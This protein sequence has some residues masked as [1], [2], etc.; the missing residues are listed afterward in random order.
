MEVGGDNKSWSARTRRDALP[1]WGEGRNACRYPEGFFALFLHPPAGRSGSWPRGAGESGAQRCGGNAS[2]APVVPRRDRG[3][4]PCGALPEG[5]PALP[6]S[7]TVRSRRSLPAAAL[8]VP[9]APPMRG[10]SRPPGGVPTPRSPPLSPLSPRGNASLLPPH[11]GG[12]LPAWSR[13]QG[14]PRPN[15]ASRP[16]SQEP[17]PFPL[18]GVPPA[19]PRLA[20]FRLP[21]PASGCG[22]TVGDWEG[23]AKGGGVDVT[24]L[25]T[26]RF[27]GPGGACPGAFR[28]W[29]GALRLPRA[30][31][32]WRRSGRSSAA[33]Q[34]PRSRIPH[35]PERC[36][37]AGKGLTCTAG[38][39]C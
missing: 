26:L 33:A 6:P 7:R 28:R 16:Q 4:A 22:G 34:V 17:F 3:S 12:P 30:K 37:K 14:S 38:L 27:P 29:D 25:Q 36:S 35:D 15:L 23:Q 11:P 1:V 20:P 2:P 13:L 9:P 19:P 8:P 24:Q 32:G 5:T 39:L 31:G 21:A 10:F 18:L